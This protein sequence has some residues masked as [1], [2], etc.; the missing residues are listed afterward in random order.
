MHEN[1]ADAV[2][3]EV[4]GPPWEMSPSSLDVCFAYDGVGRPLVFPFHVL[5][6]QVLFALSRTY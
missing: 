2:E 3:R 4:G 1:E 6:I 5:A